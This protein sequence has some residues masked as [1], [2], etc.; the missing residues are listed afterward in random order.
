MLCMILPLIL[1]GAVTIEQATPYSAQV[2]VDGEY[3]TGF[4]CSLELHEFCWSQNVTAFAARGFRAANP[5]TPD[6]YAGHAALAWWR[7]SPYDG[8]FVERR[9]REAPTVV[10][11]SGDVLAYLTEDWHAYDLPARL[12]LLVGDLT[13]DGRVSVGDLGLLS[14]RWGQS[15]TWR[16]G[17]LNGDWQV[18]VSDLGI[19]AA[20]WGA[21]V[22]EPG[23]LILLW[24]GAVAIARRRR[25]GARS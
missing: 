15:G 5:A 19:L 6:L 11:V 21:H 23:A 25:K 10:R 9:L 18:D 13:G 17:D 8:Y 2:Y 16:Q 1:C 24:L 7:P 4:A 20:Q 14:A 12:P 22:P 3:L